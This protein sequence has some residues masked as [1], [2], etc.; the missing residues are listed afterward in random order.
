[1]QESVAH[2]H[3]CVECS[4]SS[5]ETHECALVLVGVV[6]HGGDGEAG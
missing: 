3:L 5:E 6:H 1:M 4:V 2:D